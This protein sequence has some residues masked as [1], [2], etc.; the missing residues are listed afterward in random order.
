[1]ADQDVFD[2]SEDESDS[3]YGS[4]NAAE[5]EIENIVNLDP[6]SRTL[7]WADGKSLSFDESVERIYSRHSSHSRDQ[8][9]TH[10][11]S[12]LEMGDLPDG[13]SE[14]EVGKLDE[15]VSAWAEQIPRGITASTDS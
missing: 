3:W 9:H 15:L 2:M 5:K 14:D 4:L 7:I 12:W 11:R 10:L 8:L 1:M 6:V 13:L